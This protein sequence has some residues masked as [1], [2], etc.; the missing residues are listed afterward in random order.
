MFIDTYSDGRK[1]SPV[2]RTKKGLHTAYALHCGYLE[3]Y[4]KRH[5]EDSW[6]ELSCD[7]GIYSIELFGDY[8]NRY[9]HVVPKARVYGEMFD[10]ISEARAALPRFKKMCREMGGD[11]RLTT[12]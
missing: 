4:G 6:I 12:Y 7:H 2:F 11:P 3:C 8:V 9:N 5:K 10:T 1:A